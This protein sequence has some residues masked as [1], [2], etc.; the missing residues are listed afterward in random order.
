[1]R[2]LIAAANP[3]ATAR[4]R[5]DEEMRAIQY[6][7]AASPHR[8][9]VSLAAYLAVRAGD[10]DRALLGDTP[11][12]V[13]F[14]C[15]GTARGLSLVGSSGEPE[16]FPDEALTRLLALH[17]GTIRLVV[18][19]ACYS[20]PL[21]A[22]IIQTIDCAIGVPAS[23]S[24][25]VA[26]AFS[27]ALY[28][29]LGHGLSVADAY[30]RALAA[31]ALPAPGGQGRDIDTADTHLNA[32]ALNAPVLQTREGVD[33]STL[34]VLEPEEALED[35]PAASAGQL[36]RARLG[37]RARL[38][39][40]AL[41]ER[42]A[43]RVRVDD[44]ID[45]VR[46]VNRVTLFSTLS[47]MV[48]FSLGMVGG[49]LWAT[50]GWPWF[51]G[52]LVTLVAGTA[53]T[54]LWQS[55][56]RRIMGSAQP[57]DRFPIY[58][59]VAVPLGKF[60][61]SP[62]LF[63][64]AAAAG[65][66]ETVVG[67]AVAGGANVVGGA[68]AGGATGGAATS[69]TVTAMVGIAATAGAVGGY[70]TTTRQYPESVPLELRCDRDDADAC[71]RLAERAWV[72]GEHDSGPLPEAVQYAERACSLNSMAACNLLAYLIEN[73]RGERPDLRRAASLYAHACGHWNSYSCVHLNNLA[74]RYCEAKG[75]DRDV[76]RCAELFG[77]VCE[78][79]FDRAPEESRRSWQQT[80]AQGCH[81]Q[82]SAL[83]GYGE[84]SEDTTRLFS[85]A[86]EMGENY[87]CLSAGDNYARGQG[88]SKDLARA[89]DAYDKACDRRSARRCEDGDNQ[90]CA[91]ERACQRRAELPP[92][93][94]E[95]R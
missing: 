20:A 68:A 82:A 89:R 9:V 35:L 47:Y 50:R 41:A 31:T 85:K 83:Q 80:A 62:A 77:Q 67:G 72:R 29:A 21:A 14:C 81:N 15:H 48:L 56:T 64:Q 86:C 95:D 55:E 38:A 8:D 58:L 10:L 69:A 46:A 39:G 76:K 3:L 71:Y 23:L 53:V 54:M 17:A 6:E 45:L 24:D 40:I 73:E 75:V 43:G 93:A 70:E 44:P 79:A 63:G 33:A 26:I 94:R 13:H 32:A 78:I 57:I 59:T 1:M 30:E 66:E 28:R 61:A 87:A 91:A 4:L 49:V 52:T 16:P 27:A 74:K 84:A 22:R 7:I 60:A 5:L 2:V 25:D 36:L 19:N 42:M 18:L 34:F 92:E 90:T 12:V 65:A 88:V 51:A 11:T 37:R